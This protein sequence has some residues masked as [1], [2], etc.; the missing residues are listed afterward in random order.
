VRVWEGH[1]IEELILNINVCYEV[2]WS[3]T[4]RGTFTEYY[5]V[6]FEGLGREI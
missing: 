6:G 5:S 1:Y 4:E 2:T 3:A